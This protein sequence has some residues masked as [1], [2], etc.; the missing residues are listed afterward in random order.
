MERG[1]NK[2]YKSS[3]FEPNLNLIEMKPEEITKRDTIR[4]RSAWK[5]LHL[6]SLNY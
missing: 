5:K 6:L 1:T 4:K 3:H 2:R